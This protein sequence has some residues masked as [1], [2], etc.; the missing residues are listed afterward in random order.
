MKERLCLLLILIFAFSVT[1]AGAS[2][3][4]REKLR[5]EEKEKIERT[6]RFEDLSQPNVVCVDNIFGSITVEGFDGQAVKLVVHKT[7]KARNEEK[8]QKARDEVML[9]IKEGGNTIDL[10]VDGPFR[11]RDEDGRQRCRWDPGYRVHY[12]FQIRV[13]HKTILSLKTATDG[14]IHVERVEGE[15]DIRHANGEIDLIEVAGS[16]EAHTANG[17]ITVTFSKNPDSDCSFK[18]VNGDV[19]VSF[20]ENLSA[21]FRL[22]T[23]HGDGYSDFPVTYLPSRPAKKGQKDGRFVYKSDRFVGV[24]VDRGGPEILMDTLNGDLIIQKR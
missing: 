9:D 5:V 22:K 12:D 13:P 20:Q 4:D 18:T 2:T 16:G 10:Y 15:F 17:D 24:R 6:L 1:Y 23:F 3:W 11:D 14:K 7:I 21:D 8:L 19:K